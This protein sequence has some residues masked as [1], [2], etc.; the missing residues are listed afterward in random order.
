M[1]S[2]FGRLHVIK[3][4]SFE[5]VNALEKLITNPRG[6]ASRPVFQNHKSAR[7]VDEEVRLRCDENR[8]GRCVGRSGERRSFA[9]QLQ[10]A[11]ILRS[12]P[13]RYDPE[14]VRVVVATKQRR[15]LHGIE[16]N[17]DFRRTALT[18][19]LGFTGCVGQPLRRT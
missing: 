15:R 13:G 10:F 3:A 6:L 5:V 16:M 2:A 4:G 8:K 7:R 11:Q 1:D 9:V 18:F 14:H 19:D 17:L 12:A